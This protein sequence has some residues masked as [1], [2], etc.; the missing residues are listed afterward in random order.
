MPI[1]DM[2]NVLPGQAISA[3]DTNQRIDNIRHNSNLRGAPPINVLNNTMGGFQVSLSGAEDLKSIAK[4]AVIQSHAS[5]T[6]QFTWVYVARLATK[7]TPGYG[8]D[9]Y[10]TSGDSFTC[11]NDYEQINPEVS[12]NNDIYGIGITKSDLMITSDVIQ[13]NIQPVPVGT[14]IWIRGENVLVSDTIQTEFRF[15]RANGVSGECPA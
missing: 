3:F 5:D 11:Y 10:I 12:D 9:A 6:E 4:R 14:P 2:K 1:N 7:S 13:I 15:A 8:T